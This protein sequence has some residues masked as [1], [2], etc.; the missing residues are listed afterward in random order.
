MRSAP[1]TPTRSTAAP[2][3]AAL[4]ERQRVTSWPSSPTSSQVSARCPHDAQEATGR[5]PSST[6]RDVKEA[7]R[8]RLSSRR[9]SVKSGALFRGV[10]A[11]Y[12]AARCFPGESMRASV[13]SFVV[14][15]L[16]LAAACSCGEKVQTVEPSVGEL[17]DELPFGL[18][19]VGDSLSQTVQVQALTTAEL[20]LSAVIEEA[21]GPFTLEAQPPP[22]VE[23]KGTVELSIRF[24]PPA[25]DTYA[26]TLVI[27]TNDPD[28]ARAVKRIVLSGTGKSP[29]ISV[30]PSHLD[31]TAIACPPTARS[32][33]CVD[34]QAVTIENVGE[35]RLSLDKVEVVAETGG[36]LPTGLALARLVSTSAL[37]PGEK[38]DVAVRWKPSVADVPGPEAKDFKATLVIPSND[39]ANAKLEVP[40]AAHADPNH[41]PGACAQ[42]L[43]VTK[44]AYTVQS[45]GTVKVSN[46]SVPAIQYTCASAADQCVPGEIQVR[47]GMTVKLT[48]AGVDSAGQPCTVDPEG[49]A[50]SY[51]WSLASRPD[52][53]RA[54]PSP[55]AQAATAIEIDA[56]GKYTVTLV[57]RDSLLLAGTA[58]L[59]L[60]AIPRDD[61]SVQ[62]AWQDASGVDLDLHLLADA[63]PGVTDPARLFCVNDAFFFNPAPNWFETTNPLDDPRLLRDDQGTAGQLE[64]LGL[65]AAPAG[66]RYRVVVHEYDRGSGPASV[67]PKVSI[68]LKGAVFGPYTPAAPLTGTDDAWVAA[69]IVFPANGSAPTAS[70]LQQHLVPTNDPDPVAGQYTRFQ[71]SV[72]ACF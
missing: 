38:L 71:G 64:S 8:S 72:G 42:V 9:S 22:F 59:V 66:S 34:E 11:S 33:R 44:R 1:R 2:R 4:H 28:R 17:P 25:V 29:Q 18:V 36:R 31:L 24:T 46:V 3:I 57:A 15:S 41:A 13:R 56:V 58:Q 10:R 53:S 51:S 26:G 54:N 70:P 5:A 32:P 48:S 52:E 14:V 40:L 50:L 67:T 27:T 37:E 19:A 35:V 68:R 12:D 69:E 61:I 39:P 20:T 16:L 49:D 30:T 60:N 23:G 45:D 7:M 62:L 63:G 21:G 43:E 65:Q 6:E 47:P 55:D